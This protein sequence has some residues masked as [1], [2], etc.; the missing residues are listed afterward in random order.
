MG[1]GQSGKKQLERGCPRRFVDYENKR[2]GFDRQQLPVPWINTEPV[3]SE[4]N[5]LSF[6]GEA[7]NQLGEADHLLCAI[8]GDTLGRQKI[9]GRLGQ[10]GGVS[11]GSG[12]HPNCALLSYYY[13]P[14]LFQYRGDNQDPAFDL[15]EGDDAGIDFDAMDRHQHYDGDDISEVLLLPNT[16]PISLDELRQLA[17]GEAVAELASV[18]QNS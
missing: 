5:W 9:F 17:G 2:P 13:C 14:H 3:L 15:Y 16:R 10:E 8:C 6:D 12:M 4:R 7:L 11:T 18:S 1:R